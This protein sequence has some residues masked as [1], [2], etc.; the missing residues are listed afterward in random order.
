[1]F[2]KAV[3]VTFSLFLATKFLLTASHLQLERYWDSML[4]EKDEWTTIDV[5]DGL[6][7]LTLDVIGLAGSSS[8]LLLRRRVVN[9]EF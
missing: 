5:M 9:Y 8:L 6:K 1:M 4:G 7:K 3:E 2:K